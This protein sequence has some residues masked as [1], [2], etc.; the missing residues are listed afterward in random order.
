MPDIVRYFLRQEVLCN[1]RGLRVDKRVDLDI[2][3]TA[4]CS[5]ASAAVYIIICVRDN[6]V[7]SSV[8][9]VYAADVSL[10]IAVPF[11]VEAVVFEYH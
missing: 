1:V 3:D 8:G 11:A 9:G 5:R 4:R 10:A 7:I 2:S 6:A